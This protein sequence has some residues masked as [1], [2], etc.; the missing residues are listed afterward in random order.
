M[1]KPE[2]QEAVRVLDDDIGDCLVR[3]KGLWTQVKDLAEGHLIVEHANGPDPLPALS[4][5]IAQHS[6]QVRRWRD[7]RGKLVMALGEMTLSE[8]RPGERTT[9]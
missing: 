5:E 8:Q 1:T 9:S 3:L 2:I 7:E 4:N 6:R